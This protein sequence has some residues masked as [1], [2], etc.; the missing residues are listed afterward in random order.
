MYLPT[1]TAPSARSGHRASWAKYRERYGGNLIQ[2]GCAGAESIEA[3]HGPTGAVTR[4]IREDTV[5][6]NF[7]KL[8]AHARRHSVDNLKSI[9]SV[10]SWV[11][12]PGPDNPT[13]VLLPLSCQHQRTCIRAKK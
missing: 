10:T 4:A 9:L 5:V 8:A 2:V 11:T 13:T 12:A 6:I 1:A 7:K 3:P